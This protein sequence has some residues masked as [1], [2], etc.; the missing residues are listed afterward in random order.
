[1]VMKKIQEI[2]NEYNIELKSSDQ[3]I[4]VYTCKR[5]EQKNKLKVSVKRLD[6]FCNDTQPFISK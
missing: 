2:L 5:I 4:T 3:R 1:M 6:T